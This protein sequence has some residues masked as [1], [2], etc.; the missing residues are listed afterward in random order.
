MS[1]LRPAFVSDEQYKYVGK[2]ELTF[3]R[4]ADEQADLALGFAGPVKLDRPF[5]AEAGGR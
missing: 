1:A 4:H 3:A 5:D 2:R